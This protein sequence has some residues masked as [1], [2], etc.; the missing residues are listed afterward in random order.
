MVLPFALVNNMALAQTDQDVVQCDILVVGGGL[1]GSAAAYQALLAGKTVC[2]SEITDWVGGQISSQ[3]TSALDE[4]PTQRKLNF[5]PK[6]YQELTERL[7]N[8][9]SRPNPGGCW[10]STMCFLPSDG[11]KVLF[12]Q[13]QDAAIKGKGQLKWFP[14]TVIK[15]L[16]IKQTQ[17]SNQIISAI[18]IQRSPAPKAPS[19]N[20]QPLS[21][22][23]K[24]AY[25]F[26]DSALFH[27]KIIKFVPSA[28]NQGL[29]APW[30]IIEATETGELIA[31]ADLPYRLGAE[32]LSYLEPSSSSIEGDPYCLQGF[33]YTFAMERTAEPQVNPMPAFYPQYSPYYS[34]ELKRLANFDF[35]F[36]Y[37]RISNPNPGPE[38]SFSGIS[39]ATP[40]PGD[41]SMQNWTWGNDYRPGTSQDNLI[42][43]REQLQADGQLK[44]GGWLGGLRI[45]TLGKAEENALGYYYWL[46]EGTTD[47]QLGDGV[48]KPD[49]R[50]RFLKGLD[51]PMGTEHGLSKYPYIRESRHII[52]RPYFGYEDGFRITEIDISRANYQQDYYREALGPEKYRHLLGLLSGLEGFKVLDGS[53]AA[54]QVK[55][56]S[57]STIYP[58]SVGIGHYAIDLHPCLSISPPEA[59]GNR[60]K[61]GERRGQGI[62]YP[63]QIPLRSIIPQKIDNLLIS[64]KSIALSHI[65]AAAY[66]VHSFEWS[67]GIAAGETAIF[68]LE[69]NLLPYQLVENPLLNDPKLKELQLRLEKS[70]NPTAFPNTSVFNES[71]QDWK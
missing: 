68:S 52:G 32:P 44:P 55:Q 48:K 50:H 40:T 49:P 4:R 47:S 21:K 18:A 5:F 35:V 60:E 66:R 13:L 17:G 64:G 30:Y 16:E 15:D 69:K 38:T 59:P 22:T 58:D 63:F 51:S 3:G 14:A 8:H 33:T 7:H 31:L 36:T 24:D 26:K 41:I 43:T 23:I 28:K 39:Y 61:A 37:R 19:L 25:T 1:A 54:D 12:E 53:L 29:I 2:V 45:D 65:A 56:R 46:V 57:R 42:Y 70:G 9:Y 34:Y 71:W 27:K 6:G 20:S 11:H 10:V 62:A 67:S